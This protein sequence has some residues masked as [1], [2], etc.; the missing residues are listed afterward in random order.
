MPT[1]TQ[2]QSQHQEQTITINLQNSGDPALE[3]R[4]FSKH[5]VGRQ[6]GAIAAVV[7]ALVNAQPGD[8]GLQTEAA[9]GAIKAFKTM[10]EDIERQK[11]LRDPKELIFEQLEE[12][13]DSEGRAFP[14]FC[15]RLREWL[16][17]QPV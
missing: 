5:G 15:D 11:R 9:L 6:L 1:D 10:Q 3:R 2:S 12:L 17:G 16:D 14:A 4:I 7:D 8:P 13:R